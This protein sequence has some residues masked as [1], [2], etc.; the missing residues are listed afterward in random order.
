MVVGNFQANRQ[1]FTTYYGQNL[2]HRFCPQDLMLCV[3][4]KHLCKFVQKVQNLLH[5]CV[6]PTASMGSQHL[7]CKMPIIYI[8]NSQNKG[9]PRINLTHCSILLPFYL[10][11][12]PTYHMAQWQQRSFPSRGLGFKSRVLF[13]FSI[14]YD[15][16]GISQIVS[17]LFLGLGKST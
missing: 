10:P 13:F 7:V 6:I 12:F 5:E 11:K 1:F 2:S 17:A 16:I 14:I 4:E 9:L 3:Q 8:G 15:F